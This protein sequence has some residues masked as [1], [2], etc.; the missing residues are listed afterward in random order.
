MGA[1]R[2]SRCSRAWRTGFSTREN[3]TDE[4]ATATN[5]HSTFFR[6]GRDEDPAAS[7]ARMRIGQCQ[8]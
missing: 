2:P 5:S 8:R 6:N 4:A 3:V 1:H 7:A